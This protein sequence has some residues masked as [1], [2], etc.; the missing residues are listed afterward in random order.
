MVEKPLS[1]GI[2]SKITLVGLFLSLGTLFSVSL[3]SFIAADNILKDRI[4]AQLVSESTG[5]GASLRALIDSRVQQ[6]ALLATNNRIVE[7]VSQ[8]TIASPSGS[9]ND[10]TSS[11]SGDYY[12]NLFKDEL[13]SFQQ[14]VGDSMGLES[15]Q[16]VGK[17]GKVLLS[18]AHQAAVD[19]QQGNNT[20]I[21]AVNAEQLQRGLKESFL[22]FDQL[23]GQR[24]A[25]VVVPIKDTRN[26]SDSPSQPLAI[27]VATT[28]TVAFDDILLNRKGLG[29]TGEVY[30]ANQNKTMISESRFIKD[31]AFKV[32][33]DT[34][35]VNECL[36]KGIEIFN[37][38]PDYRDI[39]IVGSSYCA[40]D[41]G[42]V[43]L[44]EFDEAE[45]FSPI[46]QL[47]N[48]ILATAAVITAIVVIN[49]FYVAKTISRPV[50]KLR[51][52]ANRI[53]RG[54]YEHSV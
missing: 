17:D 4:Q 47:R 48:A 29:E 30:L 20:N 5:R 53:S 31:A 1:L 37:V 10:N 26:G 49:S 50:T 28:N 52:A 51:D 24:K 45:I 42:F 34:L 13:V 44:A 3:L 21:Y 40:I 43:L 54:D 12:N 11:N 46:T 2:K 36:G 7:I 38:Y 23:H 27:M 19:Q 8:I 35:P 14:V 41:K 18:S 33:V 25:I 16:V 15:V 32:K 6:I 9:V 39:P 22:E